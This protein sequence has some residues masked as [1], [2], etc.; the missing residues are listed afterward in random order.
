M[1]DLDAIAYGSLF[2]FA[3]SMWVRTADGALYAGEAGW[4]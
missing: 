4:L 3:G 2:Q 1:L